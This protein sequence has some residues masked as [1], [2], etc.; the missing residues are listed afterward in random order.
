MG[1]FRVVPIQPPLTQQLHRQTEF[2]VAERVQLG[3][4]KNSIRFQCDHKGRQDSCG[5]AMGIAL[6]QL[7]G[8]FQGLHACP[9]VLEASDE[10]TRPTLASALK[11]P[12]KAY[13]KTH[14]TMLS[15]RNVRLQVCFFW[16]LQ[17]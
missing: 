9:L 14:V 16:K 15:C 6:D 11:F 5:L 10:T 7:S 17:C 4:R 12:K 1:F 3:E 8:V 2:I 13:L